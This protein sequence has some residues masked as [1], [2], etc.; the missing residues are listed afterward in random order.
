[1]LV[2]HCAV[3]FAGKR[4][5]PRVSLGTLLLAALLADVMWLALTFL[6]VEQS[7]PAAAPTP[8][9]RLVALLRSRP[10]DAAEYVALQ[11]SDQKLR[12][13]A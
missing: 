7:Q 2:G 9:R 10:D 12:S 6:G 1:M 5:A 13:W 3:A 4:A 8:A 11:S